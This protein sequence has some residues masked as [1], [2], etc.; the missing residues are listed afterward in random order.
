GTLGRRI[1]DGTKKVRTF[2]EEISVN[3]EIHVLE[4][5]SGHADQE[6]IIQWL[7]NFKK[8]PKKVFLIHGEQDSLDTISDLIQRELK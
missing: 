4:G 6:E 8:R 2:G 3:A 1:Q 5:F 7:R